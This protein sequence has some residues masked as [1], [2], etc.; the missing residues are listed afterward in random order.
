MRTLNFALACMGVAGLLAGCGDDTTTTKDLGVDSLKVDTVKPADGPRPDQGPPP[1]QGPQPDGPLPDQGPTPDGPLPDQ[2]PTPDTTPTPDTAP[3][4]DQAVITPDQGAASAGL[5]ATAPLVPLVAGSAT[6]NGDTSLYSDQFAGLKCR[7]TTTVTSV[8]DGPQAYYRIAGKQDQWYRF[9][10]KSTFSSA[11]MYAFTSTLCTEAAIQTDC[12]SAGVTGASSRLGASSTSARAMYFKSPANADF[13]VAVDSLSA[14]GP[15]T[16]EIEEIAI[17]TNATC[18][19]ATPLTFFNGKAVVRGDTHETLTP[20]EY[21]TLKCGTVQMDGPQAYY[22]FDAVAGQGYKIKLTGDGNYLHYFYVFGSSCTEADIGTDC[23]SGGATGL[24]LGSVSGGAFKEAAFTAPTTGTYHIAV[25]STVDYGQGAFTLEIE[26]FTAP[27]NGVCAA[28]TPIT[29][30]NGAATV[31]GSTF[32]TVDE[33]GTAVDCTGS[34]DFDGPQAYYELDVKA[35]KFYDITLA[36]T[37]SLAYLY[38]FSQTAGCTAAGINASCGSAGDTGDYTTS[39]A[40]ASTPRAL[41]FKPT[42]PGK[43]VIAVESSGPTYFGD[44]TLDIK[45]QDAPTNDTCNAAQ[46]L[47]FTAG[48]ATASGTTR[49]GGNEYGATVD[50]TGTVDFDGPQVYYAFTAVANKGYKISYTPT[51]SS[52]LYVFEQA[53]CGTAAAINA[54]CGSVGV[55]GLSA[56][57]T[58][59]A[60]TVYFQ[61]ALAGTY[62]IALDSSDA[63]TNGT[64]DLTVE[65]LDP[66]A[67]G[68]C[69]NATALTLTNGKV[70]AQGS[71][72]FGADEYPNTVSCGTANFLDGPQAYYTLDMTAGQNYWLQLSSSFDSAYLYIFSGSCDGAGI[73]TACSS[74]GTS[75]DVLGPVSSTSKALYF[76]PSTSGTYTIVVDSDRSTTSNDEY[77]DY[78]LNVEQFGT[79]T[80]GTCAAAEQVTLTGNAAQVTGY[81]TGLADEFAGTIKCGG[82]TAFAAG[83]AY[84]KVDLTAGVEYTVSVSTDFASKAYFFPGTTNCAA[85]AIETECATN[86]LTI[87]A[88]GSS[89]FTFNPTTSGT[90]YM[91]I[92]GLTA[93]AVGRYDVKITAFVI[94]TITVPAS[95]LTLDFEANGGGF[96][97][98]GDWEWGKLAWT[99]GAACTSTTPTPPPNNQGHVPTQSGMWGTVLNTC[100]TALGNNQ[101]SSSACTTD[102][103][104]KS[105]DSVLTFNLTLPSGWTSAELKYWEFAD[106][107][108]YFDWGEVY[109]NGTVDA[110]T[111]ICSGSSAKAWQQRTINLT[112]YIGQTVN[113]AYHF[114]AS[115]VVEVAGWYIDELTVTGQ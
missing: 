62:L 48:K 102:S 72:A 76:S 16:L 98:K 105:D 83:Q 14:S 67:N 51:F 26:E 38:I 10:L 24:Y 91:V 43:Y 35:G 27:T 64:F 39:S 1:D 12:Q 85:A 37:F 74:G 84:Y 50:C 25:D 2:G 80:N 101:G 36:P 114:M 66:P 18:A 7:S 90:Y 89:N 68:S 60:Q 9:I 33:Y 54:S 104:D 31:Q 3:T 52:Y 110:G 6:I 115:T 15:F 81:T 86:V 63:A 95:G 44:F 53:A 112:P 32:G 4:P 82:T 46:T 111:K 93:A 70:T 99:G 109:V 113:I 75:G 73:Q 30:T 49:G 97:A 20:D 107:N 47:T 65:E 56:G 42:A 21:T 77:G 87:A 94:P 19:N 96:A 106:I 103:S 55:S 100:Y 92:D 71:T 5:C 29:L 79:G 40:S 108:T 59:G 88:G 28:P 11:Y 69:A 78:T 41:T 45:E 13:T 17:P 61:P 58:S 8:L 34:T 23:S 22:K 57:S